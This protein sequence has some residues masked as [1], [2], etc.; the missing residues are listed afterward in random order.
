MLH[1]MIKYVKSAVTGCVQQMAERLKEFAAYS[2]M[3]PSQ[4]DR[5]ILWDLFLHVFVCIL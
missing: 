2:V 4:P 1:N 3:F 5:F